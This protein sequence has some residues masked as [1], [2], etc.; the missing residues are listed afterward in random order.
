MNRIFLMIKI[1]YTLGDMRN[2]KGKDHGCN[3]VAFAFYNGYC[4][5]LFHNNHIL[6]F[7]QYIAPSTM[8]KG[9]RLPFFQS[10]G[11]FAT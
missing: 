5:E 6:M 10:I 9:N 11:G 4:G 8:C 3:S 1:R 7:I 2:Y